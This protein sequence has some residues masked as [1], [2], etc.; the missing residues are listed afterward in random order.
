MIASLAEKKEIAEGTLQV[1]FALPEPVSFKPGQY[2][3][4]TL[5][6]P[7]YTDNRGNK[8]HFSIVNPP[9]ENTKLILATR[10]GKSAFKKSLFEMEVGSKVEVGPIAGQF[11][12]PEYTLKPS[13][14]TGEARKLVFISGGIGITPFISMLKYVT[15]NKLGHNITLI[16]SNRNRQ[17]TPFLEELQRMAKAN[18]NLKLILIM[19]EEQSWEGEKRMIDPEFLKEYLKAPSGYQFYVVGPIP[20]VEAVVKAL[21]EFGAPEENIKI[22]NFSGY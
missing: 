22:E 10:S 9:S 8:R 4:V 6:N 1:E 21:K 17:S 20:M 3:F 13:V 5:I 16:F 11:V 19:T 18:T 15:E 14:F 2:F 12:L 7:P